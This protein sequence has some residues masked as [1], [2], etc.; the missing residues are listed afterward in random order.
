M[1][2]R[3]RVLPLD[4]SKPVVIPEDGPRQLLSLA[5][6]HCPGVSLLSA[7]LVSSAVCHVQG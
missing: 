7:I 3:P 5:L 2:H 6:E 1:E 4:V